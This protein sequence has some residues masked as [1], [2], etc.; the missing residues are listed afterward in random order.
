MQ[1]AFVK[2]LIWAQPPCPEAMAGICQDYLLLGS[3]SWPNVLSGAMIEVHI[4]GEALSELAH[5]SPMFLTE[6]FRK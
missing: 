5:L 1:P 4:F 6:G 3:G 2:A